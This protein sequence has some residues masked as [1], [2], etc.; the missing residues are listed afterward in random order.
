MTDQPQ[1]IFPAGPPAR[2]TLHPMTGA[3]SERA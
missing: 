1:P 3:L 2:G